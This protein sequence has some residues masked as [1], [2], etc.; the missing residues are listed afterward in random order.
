M[1]LFF[2]MRVRRAERF[3]SKAFWLC[4]NQKWRV[5]ALFR[6]KVFAGSRQKTSANLFHRWTE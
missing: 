3:F 5:P 2:A 4:S 1:G 6:D